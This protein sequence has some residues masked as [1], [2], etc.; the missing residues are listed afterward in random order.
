MKMRNSCL[1]DIP[2]QPEDWEPVN[3]NLDTVKGGVR[4]RNNATFMNTPFIAGLTSIQILQAN[5][6][7]VY[8]LVQ[9]NSTANMYIVFN[10]NANLFNGLIIAAGGNYEPYVAP[11]SG[12]YVIGTVAGLNGVI[13]EGVRG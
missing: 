13:I 1:G 12:I 10:N 3:P 6:N 9:N 5:L 11:F 4:W 8:L 7:R 2:D